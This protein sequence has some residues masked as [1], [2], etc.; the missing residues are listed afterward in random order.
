MNK[1]VLDGG[2]EVICGPMFAGKTE[3][4]L[5]RLNRM[6]YAKIDY[7]IFK[8]LIDTRS[9]HE[10]KSRNGKSE[11]AVEIKWPFEILNYL[12]E[13]NLKP[14]VIAIDEAQFFDESIVEV[15][16][17]LGNSG[18]HVI[19][20]GLDK[21]FKGESFGPIPDLLVQADKITK[22]SAIC[23]VCGSEALFSQRLIN[24]APAD[25]DSK[26]ILIGDKESYEARCRQHFVIPNCPLDH[27]SRE[28]LEAIE[29]NKKNN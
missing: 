9:T 14:K 13:N 29:K 27:T 6:R 4:L 11:K 12:R 23:T 16:T 26:I 19:L 5:R 20:A 22:L 28:F 25:Y 1:I 7:I 2:I 24:N 21:N 3:E 18:F 8:P 10:I 17:V 15:A